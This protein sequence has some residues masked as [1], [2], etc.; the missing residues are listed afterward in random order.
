LPTI[1][2]QFGRSG[3]MWI[4]P[5]N[6]TTLMTILGNLLTGY[7]GTPGG[8]WNLMAIFSLIVLG[9]SF[10]LWCQE[11]KEKF[12][13]LLLVWLLWPV[14]L[15]LLISCFKPIYVNRY[16]IFVTVAEVLVSVMAISLIKN[17][18]IRS[19]ALFGLLIFLVVFSFWFPSRHKK[20]DIRRT[21]TEVRQLAGS[22]DVV[23]AQTPLT[24]FET[25]YYFSQTEKN[26]L[27]EDHLPDRSRVFLYNPN[28]LEVPFYAGRNLI[29]QDKMK[30]KFPSYPN[31]A[32]LIHDDGSYEVFSQK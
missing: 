20:L 23:F 7:E 3:P 11:R 32:F 4:W 24:F 21:I 29:T 26:R 9:L 22:Q 28:H 15:V 30:D 25:S 6:L 1:L 18:F 12:Y 8:L 16:L 10:L 13:L 17:Q 14:F 27:D 2:A 31:R 19:L 5:I